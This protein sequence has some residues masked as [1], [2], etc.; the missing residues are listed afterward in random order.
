MSRRLAELQPPPSA[1]D[2]H[3]VEPA[4]EGSAA[5]L[6]GENQVQLAVPQPQAV[7]EAANEVVALPMAKATASPSEAPAAAAAPA[8]PAMWPAVLTW[9]PQWMA[10]AEATIARDAP[11]NQTAAWW[12]EWRRKWLD[13]E[14]ASMNE[15]LTA[16]RRSLRVADTTEILVALVLQPPALR[17]LPAGAR[18]GADRVQT[19]DDGELRFTR[20]AVKCPKPSAKAV[21][22]LVLEAVARGW[23]SLEISGSN[24]FKLAVAHAASARGLSVYERSA[25]GLR[26]VMEAG[27]A[28]AEPRLR[29]GSDD[30]P[31]P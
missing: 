16:L 3:L 7:Q 5:T 29:A 6:E 11:T 1:D 31:Q 23:S 10:T 12:A 18:F 26:M 20:S 25:G 2:D 22:L 28:A 30:G 13:G 21:E 15:R 4:G 14:V 9:P 24:E 17:S 27:L 19:A 8:R